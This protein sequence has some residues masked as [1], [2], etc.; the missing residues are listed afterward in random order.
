[1][2][3]RTIMAALVIPLLVAS[4]CVVSKSKYEA[5]MVDTKSAKVELEKAG[6]FE[7][8]W[9]SRTAF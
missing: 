7:R 3:S 2:Q 1:M 5:A 6:W 8:P 9:R 4:G